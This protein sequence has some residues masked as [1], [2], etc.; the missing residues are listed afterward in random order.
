MEHLI[1]QVYAL[2]AKYG[3]PYDFAACECCLSPDEKTALLATA[4]R[5]LTADQLGGYAADVFFTM[6]EVP[7]FKYF[8]PRILELSVNDQFLWP[9]PEVVARKLTLAQWLNWP[10]EEQTVITE[11][12]KM[13]FTTLLDDPNIDASETDKW[14]CALGRCFHDPTPF[15][16]P[17]LEPRHEDKLLAF[18]E[19]NGSLFT[20]KK[21]DNPFWQDA[22]D[23]EELVV[24]WLHQ[25]TVTNLLSERYGMV[26]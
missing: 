4:L 25:P 13:K 26:S 23:S 20:K 14:I 2:F 7:D 6:G 10:A 11:L 9:D 22:H 16:K 8:L 21:L 17:L 15:L 5:E 1:N 12:L 19:Y 3:K 18:I 24:R